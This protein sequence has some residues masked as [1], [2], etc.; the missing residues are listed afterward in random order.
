MSLSKG[1]SP[2]L[3]ND[4]IDK[5]LRQAQGQGSGLSGFP[6]FKFST[7]RINGMSVTIVCNNEIQPMFVYILRFGNR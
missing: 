1:F 3:T 7:Q 5:P 4:F 6:I 2:E